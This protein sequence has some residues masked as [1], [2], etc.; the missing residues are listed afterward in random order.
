MW[1][2]G[3]ASGLDKRQCTVQ[4]TIFADGGIRVKPMVIFRGQGKRISLHEQLKYDKRVFVRFQ[5]N[6]WCD[7]NIM[8]WWIRHC[9]K[10]YLQDE[11]LLILDVHTAQKTEDIKSL[12]TECDT[13]PVFVP[14]GCTSLVQP[15]D[16]SFNAPFKK[17]VENAAMQHMQD[18]L[19][20][21]M[22]GKFT[23]SE[24]CIMLTKWI[25]EAWETLSQNKEIAVRSFKKCGISVA[26][27]G[28]EDFEIN[29]EGL[30]DYVAPASPVD[31]IESDDPFGDLSFDSEDSLIDSQ[32]DDAWIS[33]IEHASE[34]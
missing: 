34:L 15:L 12:L 32:S 2:K 17:L 21:Y 5:I 7:E 28:S 23:A 33:D 25:G 10:P 1:V 31:E 14:P 26:T 22:N 13:I 3:I 8:K 6:A 30:E 16:V 4:L 19:E 11:T 27:D 24:R 18:N 29:I 9:W 20:R